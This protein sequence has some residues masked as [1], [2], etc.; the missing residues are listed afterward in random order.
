M[1]TL[2]KKN[3]ITI[4]FTIGV[5]LLSD[6]TSAQI[7]T[8]PLDSLQQ[9]EEVFIPGKLRPIRLVEST[10]SVH[11]IGKEQRLSTPGITL[12]EAFN[13]SAGI[14]MEERSPGSYRLSVRGSLLRSP[15]GV[16][17]IKVYW[18]EIP[19][20]DASGNTY[21]NLIDPSA[22]Q[23]ATILKGPDGSLFGANS[24]GVVHVNL[25]P[26]TDGLVD[27]EAQ[28]KGGSYGL[29]QQHVKASWN[30]QRG[31]T[32]HIHQGFQ[33]Q[34]GYREH[35][36][37]QRLYLQTDHQWQYLPTTKVE[38]Y[39]MYADL[40]YQTPGGLTESQWQTNPKSA[41][42]STSATPG[43]RQ[44]RAGIQNKT[45]LGGLV[46]R[47]DLHP[48]W[49]HVVSVFGS[50]TDFAN[51]FITNYETREEQNGG[52]RT[53]LQH[54]WSVHQHVELRTFAGLEWQKTSSLI[55]NTFNLEGERGGP[56]SKDK[57]ANLQHFY[58]LRTHLDWKGK[59]QLEMGLS[60]NVD[61]YRYQ[62]L[63]PDI[64]EDQKLVQSPGTWMPRLGIHVPLAARSAWRFSISKGYS[65]PTMAE[66]RASDQQINTQL[67]AE[68][69]WNWETGWRWQS[70]NRRLDLD[71][72][73]FRYDLQDAIVRY[74]DENGDESF[75]NGGNV[76]MNGVELEGNYWLITPQRSGFWRGWRWSVQGA[77]QDYTYRNRQ[78][79]DDLEGKVLPG[80]PHWTINSQSKWQLG[81]WVDVYLQYAFQSR[82]F[83]NDLNTS[84]SKP[85]HIVQSRINVRLPIQ[86][87]TALQ[88][89]AGADNL[90]NQNYS[91]GYDLNAFGGRYYNAAPLRNFYFGIQYKW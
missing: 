59:A 66:I 91:L 5:L 3:F 82:I 27:G 81:S 75:R 24:G 52:F 88:V 68:Q 36:A 69:G 6:H 49:Q 4:G 80:V 83:L 50:N 14:R 29:F 25:T 40:D 11:L 15:F 9:L 35:S 55:E 51:P 47:W 63:Y 86:G 87:M 23:S 73:L 79:T 41:R 42:P 71:V 44:Q 16:R 62:T 22:L 60:Y 65:P 7:N 48:S 57:V 30:N 64:M 17:N 33:D 37:M 32:G 2:L 58:F 77:I 31:Y 26:E 89:F 54:L 46:H 43:A 39:G 74:L 53:Y 28:L 19:L 84:Q 13:Q 10:T 56:Q 72:S 8:K 70:S 20:T 76:R 90:L 45:L 78:E 1:Y 34:L 18:G 61:Q 12:L 67:R 21:F 85:S 38:I